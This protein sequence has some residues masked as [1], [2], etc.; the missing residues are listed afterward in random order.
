MTSHSSN[1][2]I[3]KTIGPQ[4]TEWLKKKTRDE[5]INIA[6]KL[7]I[8]N[9]ES[10]NDDKLISIIKDRIYQSI[11]M[12]YN[13]KS[14]DEFVFI[15][16]SLLESLKQKITNSPPTNLSNTF[17]SSN[18]PG[19]LSKDIVTNLHNSSNSGNE[20]FE[21]SIPKNANNLNES[22]KNQSAEVPNTLNLLSFRN[23]NTLNLTQNQQ[24]NNSNDPTDKF[25]LINMNICVCMG[26]K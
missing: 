24:Q 6:S 22:N 1:S 4:Y 3:E 7:K 9:L 17:A 23:N 13:P 16:K 14:T 21:E 18:Q 20:I 26:K 15:C 2:Y 8:L 11:Q 5:K 25:K 12:R 19:L 10:I